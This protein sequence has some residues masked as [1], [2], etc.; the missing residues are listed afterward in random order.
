M[1]VSRRSLLQLHCNALMNLADGLGDEPI[2]ISVSAEHI[3]CGDR[4]CT[5]RYF[6]FRQYPCRFIPIQLCT[7]ITRVHLTVLTKYLI[8]K[9]Q[10][11]TLYMNNT[12]ANRGT[13]P[14][15]GLS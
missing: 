6:I 11:S 15:L 7:C 10:R 2:R 4:T 1:P 14:I 13:T 5:L 3:F 8:L 12:L 9:N